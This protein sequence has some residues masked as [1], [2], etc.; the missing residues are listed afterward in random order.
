MLRLSRSLSGEHAAMDRWYGGP[1][2]S[3]DIGEAEIAAGLA[4]LARRRTLGK[5]AYLKSL[6]RLQ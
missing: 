3:D 2:D 5:A 6:E 4:K 1:Y